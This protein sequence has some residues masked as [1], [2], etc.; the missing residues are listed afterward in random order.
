MPTWNDL[1]NHEY[2]IESDNND[3]F[4]N[5]PIYP[6]KINKKSRGVVN[7]NFIA[8]IKEGKDNITLETSNKNDKIEH[9][10]EPLNINESLKNN[11]TVHTKIKSNKA[12]DNINFVN[13]S[14]KENNII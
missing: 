4:F 12:H 6:D 3:A 2:E 10:L 13:K 14:S 5:G 11:N 8:P 7:N 9:E 1:Y